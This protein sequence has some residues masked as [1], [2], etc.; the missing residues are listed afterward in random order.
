MSRTIKRH[1]SREIALRLVG[2]TLVVF[3]I[4]CVLLGVMAPKIVLPGILAVLV[5]VIMLLI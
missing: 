4:T 3:G 1:P 2:G 5:G